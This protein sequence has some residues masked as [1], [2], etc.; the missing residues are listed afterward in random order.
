MKFALCQVN[1]TVGAFRANLDLIRTWYQRAIDQGA[2]VVVFPELVITGYPPGDL[3]YEGGFVN[4]NLEMLAKF[5]RNVSKPAIVGF[6]DI[7]GDDLF[8]CAALIQ[9]GAIRQVYRK[10]LLPTYDVFDE[11][12]Y[13][14]PGSGPEV[15]EIDVNGKSIRCGIEI[16]E[17]LWDDS[18]PVK[19]TSEL[20]RAGAEIIVNISASPYHEG[21]LE[22]RLSLIRD[23]V[24]EVKIPFL[25]CNLVGGQDELVF[26]GQSL[27]VNEHGQLTGQ[28]AAFREDLLLINPITDLPITDL[29]TF[30]RE[31]EI[32]EALCLGVKDYISKVGYHEVVIGMSGGIDSSLVAAIAAEALGPANVHGIAMPSRF[33]SDH[34]VNDARQLAENLGID[35]K[36]IPIQPAVDCFE[37]GLAAEFSGLARDI[38]EENNQ[39]RTRGGILMAFSNKMNWLVLSCGNKTEL[40]LG[41]CTLYG[42]MVGGLAVISDLSK[43]DVYNLARWINKKAGREIIPENCINK[44]PSAELSPDQVDPFD[45]E[46]VSPLVDAIVEERKAP[47]ELIV[48]GYD[49]ELV[50]DIYR[51]VHR[52]EYK[53]RQAAPGIRVSAKAFGS[54]RRVPI[55]N[56]FDGLSV[57]DDS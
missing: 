19:V 32:F 3:L 33:S 57:E 42:D 54:G 52:N 17:D 49:R 35:F 13:F 24:S 48:Q 43:T 25:Y 8:N 30:P 51:K 18:Y 29:V 47:Q 40:A 55:V 56:H 12:R 50:E 26:D 20:V 22:D 28:G 16:C 10:L 34:S 37:A 41:Y 7:E 46:V 39:A 15:W 5:V 14:T 38:T 11:D 21:R 44:P 53:R 36:V 9:D 31:Q 4:T 6:I 1:P 2:D 27:A 45:Y 23:K